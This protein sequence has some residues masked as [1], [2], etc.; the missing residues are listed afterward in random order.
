MINM[1]R[2]KASGFTLI[3]L[4]IVALIIAVLASLILPRFAGNRERALVS[5]AVAMLGAIRQAELANQLETGVFV[6][7][8]PP[9][10]TTLGVAPGGGANCFNYAVATVAGVTTATATRTNPA[11]VDKCDNPTAGTIVLNL[12]TGAWSGTHP[13]APT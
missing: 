6:L 2:R 5:E 11:G 1:I 9:N 3:E 12:T 10:W 13:N 4:L 8:A 7:G